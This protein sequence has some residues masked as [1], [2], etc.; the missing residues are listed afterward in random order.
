M[1]ASWSRTSGPGHGQEWK[2]HSWFDLPETQPQN[3]IE[4]PSPIV[5]AVASRRFPFQWF[6]TEPSEFTVKR[7]L[8]ASVH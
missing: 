8:V 6:W 7:K 5:D 3:A 2:T 1:T 4:S